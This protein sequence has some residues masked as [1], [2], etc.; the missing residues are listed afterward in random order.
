M[1]RYFYNLVWSCCLLFPLSFQ[2][3]AQKIYFSDTTN[4]WSVSRGG[5]MGPGGLSTSYTY[6]F[7]ASDTLV[8][9]NGQL[10]TEIKS[11]SYRASQYFE[12]ALV[13]DDT[14]AGLVYIKPQI[15]LSGIYRV[16]DTNEF[17]YM[18]YNLNLGDTLV[19]PL[20]FSWNNEDSNSIHVVTAVDSYTIDN[21]SYKKI[22]FSAY[23]GMGNH[24][25]G[26]ELPTRYTVY[27]GIGPECGPIF[28]PESISEYGGPHLI[29]FRNR[30]IIPGMFGEDC[31]DPVAIREPQQR[32]KHFLFYP[33]PALDQLTV[34]GYGASAK[35]C[36]V[37]IAD[38]QGKVLLETKFKQETVLD[39][40]HFAAGIY[41]LQFMQGDAVVQSDKLIIRR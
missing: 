18:N 3:G 30:G 28:E 11:E 25:N 17:V 34:R 5:E 10:Y 37:K 12:R 33:N 16:T 13:R 31:F 1:K 36:A 14:A 22:D 15:D 26:I 8:E 19:M 2:A 24:F 38:L 41:I 6:G 23:K 29:C 39:V 4:E 32:I 9:R 20:V 27:E 7:Y 40:T 21:T 35:N